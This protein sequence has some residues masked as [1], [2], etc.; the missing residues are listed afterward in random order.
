MHTNNVL[1]ADLEAWSAGIM[2]LCMQRWAA[3]AYFYF[4]RDRSRS[5][6]FNMNFGDWRVRL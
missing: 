1:F 2:M 4:L 3:S 5:L 6:L